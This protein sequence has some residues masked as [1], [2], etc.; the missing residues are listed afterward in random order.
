MSKVT[1]KA[2]RGLA[3]PGLL[4]AATVLA[5]QAGAQD[6]PVA[7]NSYCGSTTPGPPPPPPPSGYCTAPGVPAGCV[8]QP[9]CSENTALTGQTCGYDRLPIGATGCTANDFVGNAQVTSNTITLCQNNDTLTN[10]SLTFTIQSSPSNRYSPGLFIGEQNQPLNASGGTCSVVTF[11]TTSVGIPSDPTPRTPFPW[12]AANAGDACGSYAG[13][14]ISSQ[15]IDGVTF[16]CKLDPQTGHPTLTFMVVYAQ[17]AAGAA[18]CTGPANV[19]PGT[20]SK[21]TFGGTPVTNVTVTFNADPSC[22]GK[23]VTF[24][25]VAQTVTSTFTLVNNPGQLNF[26]A[27][28]ADG[29]TFEDLVPGPVVVRPVGPTGVTCTSAD[30]AVCDLTGTSGNDVKGTITTFPTGSHVTVTIVGDVSNPPA[31]PYTN[32]ATLTPPGT[33]T[34]GAN[35]TGNDSCTNFTSLPVK[36]QSFDVK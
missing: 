19:Y 28:S 4:L 27:D 35:V 34:A 5:P 36:L 30:G 32:T 31:G 15:T 10:Q 7:A 12:F 29:T 3:L 25:P 9:V 24:D 6:V 26:P 2:V 16:K 13:S 21:C 23:T 17:N 1:R 8:N 11:P 22:S 33:L 20:T 14:F 18:N